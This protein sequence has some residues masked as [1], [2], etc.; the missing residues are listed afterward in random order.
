MHWDFFTVLSVL[1]GIVLIA[2]AL[3][4]PVVG[5]VR[6]RLSIFAVGAFSFGYGVWVATQTSGFYM[7]SVAPAALAVGIILRAVQHSGQKKR[8]A[9][10]TRAPVGPPSPGTAAAPAGTPSGAGAVAGAYRAPYQQAPPQPA[11]PRPAPP[12][13]APPRPAPPRPAPPQLAPRHLEAPGATQ[14]RRVTVSALQAAQPERIRQ[15]V[16]GNSTAFCPV[17]QL[18]GSAGLSAPTGSSDYYLAE[19]LA[20][21]WSMADGRPRLPPG[22]ELFGIWQAE[23]RIK[24][25]IG[26]DLNP[27]PPRQGVSWVTVVDGTGLIALSRQRMIGTVVRGD[28]LLGAF[29]EAGDTGIALWCLPLLRCSSVSVTPVGHS[30]GLILSSAEPAGHVTLTGISAAEVTGRQAAGVPPGHVAE[31][32]NRARA[33]LSWSVPR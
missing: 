24:V 3:A 20:L 32:I 25:A 18:P 12:Q 14:S 26:N 13:P 9:G 28:S 22:E 5:T 1:S 30:E 33:E 6:E 11:P 8:A 15:A 27:T 10:P 23:V 4:G 7:F 16:H 2:A 29:D 17:F 19:S 21:G 31:M